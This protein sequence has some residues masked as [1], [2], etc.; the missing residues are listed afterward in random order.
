MDSPNDQAAQGGGTEP[1]AEPLFGCK[2]WTI[3]MASLY[4]RGIYLT[5]KMTGVAKKFGREAKVSNL[6]RGVSNPKAFRCSAIKSQVNS[7]GYD[8]CTSCSIDV[9]G[10]FR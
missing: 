1:P 6:S 10:G 7:I 8:R 4:A 5:M 9:V 2:A 3:E